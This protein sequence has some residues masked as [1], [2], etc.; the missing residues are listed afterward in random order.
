MQSSVPSKKMR[1]RRILRP[2]EEGKEYGNFNVKACWFIY[3]CTKIHTTTPALYTHTYCR[4]CD[5]LQLLFTLCSA[6]PE[7]TIKVG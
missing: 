4:R 6:V 3:S 5:F 2:T 1:D 7:E